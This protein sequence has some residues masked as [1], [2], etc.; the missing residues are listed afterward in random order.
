MTRYWHKGM[1]ECNGKRIVNGRFRIPRPNED[2]RCE[3]L[4][5]TT[6]ANDIV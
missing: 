2:D 5:N 4:R 6:E 1:T 3:G